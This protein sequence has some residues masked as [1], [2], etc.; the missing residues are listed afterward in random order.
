[1]KRIGLLCGAALLTLA[2][3]LPPAAAFAEPTPSP[4]ASAHSDWM[5][6]V[7]HGEGIVKTKTGPVRV[8][9]QNGEATKI[10][11][12][13]LT[14]RSADGF[15]RTWQLPKDMKVHGRQGSLQAGAEVSVFG[16][17]SG[18]KSWTAKH[19]VVRSGSAS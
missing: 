16:T 11:D 13:A 18:E 14:V 7:L 8:A 2:G 12:T 17:A 3:T 15:T 19:V 4:S 10:T 1:M 6:D 5:G 9:V